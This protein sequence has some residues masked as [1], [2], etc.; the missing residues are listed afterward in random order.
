[1][2]SCPYCGN[3]TQVYETPEGVIDCYRCGVNQ[4]RTQ[5]I[6][7]GEGKDREPITI[8]AEEP[9]LTQ[10]VQDSFRED[11]R[12]GEKGGG[13]NGAKGRKKPVKRGRSRVE[14]E[15]VC[16]NGSAG[17]SIVIK[18]TE[19][20]I[21]DSSDQIRVNLYVPTSFR[22]K[23][24]REVAAMNKV[25]KSKWKRVTLVRRALTNFNRKVDAPK[26]FD[27]GFDERVMVEVGLFPDEKHLLD[28]ACE[29]HKCSHGEFVAEC[30]DL[31]SA[32][33]VDLADKK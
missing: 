25:S 17:G 12:K 7:R 30:V 16:F 20:K 19:T 15:P 31:F 27:K 11:Q 5:T 24:D 29:H 32:A 10:Q 4:T 2:D 3:T 13:S 9:T 33:Q 6:L 26:G 8:K 28:L 23:L 14:Q 21:Y 1:M 22:D 18:R